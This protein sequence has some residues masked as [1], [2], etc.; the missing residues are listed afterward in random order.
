MQQNEAIQ[1]IGDAIEK[2]IQ[3]R[4][5]ITVATDLVGDKILDSLDGMVF[6]MELE[7]LSGRKFPEEIDLVEQG[8]FKIAKLVEFLSA[9]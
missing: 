3:K 7:I 1:L 8:Y 4:V 2:V 6:A 5:E 9:P